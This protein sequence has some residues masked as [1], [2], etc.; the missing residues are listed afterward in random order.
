MQFFTLA[1]K[2]LYPLSHLSSP[3]EAYNLRKTQK[4]G[5]NT[6]ILGPGICEQNLG[7]SESKR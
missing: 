2:A 7:I 5:Q 3:Q 4:G 6:Q 1:R